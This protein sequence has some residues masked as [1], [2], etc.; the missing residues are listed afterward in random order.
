MANII[1]TKLSLF[2][3]SLNIKTPTKLPK[4]ITPISIDEKTIEG[5]LAKA[6][7]PFI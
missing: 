4:T 3:F 2:S 7:K 6:F 5:L 1:P